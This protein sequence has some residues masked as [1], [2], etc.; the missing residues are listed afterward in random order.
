MAGVHLLP[1]IIFMVSTVMICGTVVSSKGHWK[2]WFFYGGALVLA[3]GALMFTVD[4]HTSTAKTYGYSILIG[5]GTGA[6][7]Q[8]PF[9]AAQEFVSSAE[10]PAAVGLITWAQLAAPAISLSIANAVFLNRAKIGL[11][12]ILPTD[13]PFLN[14]VSGVG[15]DYILTLEDR[16]KEQ[17]VHTIVH[18]MAESYILIIVAGGLTLIQTTVLCTM[19]G[20][21]RLER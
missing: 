6:Y 7:I 2:P 10:I 9:N 14:I 13:A 17:V 4:E 18:S 3:G 8:M 15:K 21:A 16:T 11:G 5:T 1:F 19:G 20:K 12:A